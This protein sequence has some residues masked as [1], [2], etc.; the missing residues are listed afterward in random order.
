[1]AIEAKTAPKRIVLTRARGQNER[2]RAEL[3]K[4]LGS[5]TQVVA[6]PC[7]EFSEAGETAAL[8]DAIRA[9]DTFDWILFTSQNAAR[10]FAGRMRALGMEPSQREWKTRIGAIGPATAEAANAES[11]TVDFV[12]PA[13]TGRTFAGCFKDSVRSVAGM[14]VKNPVASFLRDARGMKILVPR[15]DLALRDRGAADWTEALRDAGANVETVTAYRTCAPK[16]LAGDLVEALREGADCFVF[17]SPSAFENFGKAAGA[18]RLQQLSRGVIFAAIGPT[19]ASAIRASG[20]RCDIE[21]PDPNPRSLAQ[22]IAKHLSDSGHAA[23][24]STTSR[25]GTRTR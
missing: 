7:V 9:I 11:F 13:G 12:P 14:E 15:S 19:T 3:L 18:E 10:Y 21:S 17:A 24:A 1:M 8:D 6:L 20:L 22:S 4:A 16:E 25:Q 2:L 23:I 5:G